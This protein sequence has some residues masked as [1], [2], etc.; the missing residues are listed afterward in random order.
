MNAISLPRLPEWFTQDLRW[1]TASRA[2]RSVSQGYLSVIVV[3][4]LLQLSFNA[5]SLGELFTIGAI[6]SSLLTVLVSLLADQY[7]RKPF[8][9]IFPLLTVVAGIVFI[10]TR[11]FWILV[12]AASLGT[13]GRAGGAGGAGTGG[14]FYPAQQALIADH[15]PNNARNSVFAAF[16]LTDTLASTVGSLLAGIPDLLVNNAQWTS[17]DSYKPLFV[18]TSILGLVTALAILPVHDPFRRRQKAD[19]KSRSFLPRRSRNVI[20][21][22]AITNLVNGFGVGFFAPFIT[23]WFN[24]RF[25]SGPG[26][27]G[28][29][30]AIVNLGATVPY[31]LAPRL[32][33]RLGIVRAVVG[34]RLLGVILLGLLPIMPTFSLAATIYFFR[35]IS[36]R[37]SIPLRQ[38]YSMGVVDK[39]ERSAAAGISNLPSQ[40]SSAVSPLISGYIFENLSLELPFEI[41]AVLQLINAALFYSLFRNIRPP[42]ETAR[43]AE[44]SPS[45]ELLATKND[46]RR[47]P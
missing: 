24:A 3:L 15:A 18:L 22:L 26:T 36:Q 12:A 23:Y 9:I 42:E 45:A 33:R 46:L 27:L 13:L 2:A 8:L 5:V 32:A 47:N 20:G 31:L 10:S 29:L 7:G 40:V 1:I 11:N 17:V 44:T 34:V 14:P 21:R 37:L 43:L 4:Y 19:G 38:S 30:F 28:I 6:I 35:M 41:A 25:G 39:E 16:S